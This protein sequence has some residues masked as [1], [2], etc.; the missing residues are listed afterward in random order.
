M[1]TMAHTKIHFNVAKRIGGMERLNLIIPFLS[2]EPRNTLTV[3]F[4]EHLS[5]NL[6]QY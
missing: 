1:P 2:L 4:H 5:F 3:R 6:A